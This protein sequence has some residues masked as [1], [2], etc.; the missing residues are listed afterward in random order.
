M[1]VVKTNKGIIAI[2][3]VALLV[4]FFAG[5]EYKA[6]QIRSAVNE[7]VGEVNSIFGSGADNAE[8]NGSENTRSTHTNKT[9]GSFDEEDKSTDLEDAVEVE[10]VS[11]NF[12]SGDYRDWLSFN[13]RYTNN[14]DKN[15]RGV[16][17]TIIFYDIFGNRIYASKLSYDEGIEANRAVA[18]EAGVE[19]NQFMDDHVKLRTT[20]LENLDYEWNPDMV[21]FED[22]TKLQ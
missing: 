13:F 5:M 6:Y 21:I 14:T 17:G 12:E 4:G 3:V 15:I 2:A 11:K 22:G 16:Q 8:S 19:Y 20:K 9:P 7:A 10:V 1:D 18:E